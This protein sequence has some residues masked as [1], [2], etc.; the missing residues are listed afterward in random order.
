[1]QLVESDADESK[2]DPIARMGFCPASREVP[3]IPLFVMVGP[4]A[5]TYYSPTR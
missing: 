4:L 5:A 2:P 1:M 3:S